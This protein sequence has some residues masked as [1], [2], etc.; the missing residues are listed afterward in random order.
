MR[1][2]SGGSGLSLRSDDLDSVGEL[3]TEDNFRQLVMAAQTIPTF[4]CGLCQL[5][6]HSESGLVG[7]TS[8]RSDGSMPD[9]GEGALNRV[10]RTQMFP[11][12]GRKVV[13]GEQR[14]TILAEALDS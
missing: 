11:V 5:V 4:L 13:E 14:F 10:C 8:P 9:G 12:L 7:K 6:D 2:G 3:Y 1:P